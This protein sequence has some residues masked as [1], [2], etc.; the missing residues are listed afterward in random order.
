MANDVVIDQWEQRTERSNRFSLRLIVWIA[1][2]LGPLVARLLL[3]P[4]TLYFFVAAPGSRRASRGYLRRVLKR[5]VGWT[6]VFRHL[7]CFATTILDR[8]FLLTD[9]YSQFDIDIVNLELLEKYV[10]RGKGVILL[11]S[12][13]GS[14]D[15]MR[16]IALE[17]PEIE[18]KVLM[19]RN[20]NPMITEILEALKPGFAEGVL[21]LADSNVLLAT[22]EALDQGQ[23]VGMLGDRAA[24]DAKTVACE[25]LGT[26][27]A[28][29]LGP[30]SLAAALQVPV[31]MFFSLY[32]GKGKYRIYFELLG[33]EIA[34]QRRRNS[35]ELRPWVCR[36]AQTVEHYA[37]IAPYNW[38]NFYDFWA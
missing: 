37:R 34:V 20:H 12:H 1:L 35:D 29:P 8:V 28:F 3:Y 18:L 38:F 24:S 4:I 32:R 21:D 27:A 22:K 19:Y 11:G 10:A 9:R 14:F 26:P 30:V 17:R 13:L 33:E 31:V 7:H 16:A 2:H 23:L 15:A 5:P 6:D 36:Y 25:F